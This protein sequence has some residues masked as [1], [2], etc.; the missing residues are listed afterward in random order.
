[1]AAAAAW[2]SAGAGTSGNRDS[3]RSFQVWPFDGVI[4]LAATKPRTAAAPR[5]GQGCWRVQPAGLA[6]SLSESAMPCT[7]AVIAAV[8]SSACLARNSASPRS[9]FALAGGFGDASAVLP[10]LPVLSLFILLHRALAERVR[11]LLH[12]QDHG[13]GQPAE[14]EP[15]DDQRAEP[16]APAEQRPEP[17]GEAG[18]QEDGGGN[19]DRAAGEEAD[20]AEAGVE[21]GVADG[22]PHAVH[23]GGQEVAE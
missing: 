22:H 9:L 14:D 4:A 5:D 12:H 15:A 2:G 23:L 20:D 17:A 21:A 19:D 6:A 8:A 13:D 18:E 11:E 3:K 7:T 16:V 10:T 1:M